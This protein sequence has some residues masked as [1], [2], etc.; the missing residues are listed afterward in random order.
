MIYSL[1][2][3]LALCI[4][5]TSYVLMLLSKGIDGISEFFS[6]TGHCLAVAALKMAF[7][8]RALIKEPK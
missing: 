7:F 8:A 2:L 6:D 5:S 3:L 1:K 4:A